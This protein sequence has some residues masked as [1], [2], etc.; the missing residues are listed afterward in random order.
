MARSMLYIGA[1]AIPQEPSASDRHAPVATYGRQ[2]RG[3]YSAC[4]GLWIWAPRARR[5]G[6]RPTQLASCEMCRRNGG[7]M[8]KIYTLKI[9]VP[10]ACH[11]ARYSPDLGEHW[12]VGETFTIAP[13]KRQTYKGKT[14][15]QQIGGEETR[16]LFPTATL[17]TYF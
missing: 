15:M 11:N 13:K 7:F 9:N 1:R 10:S 6:E 14:M 4:R 16:V 17:E 3:T 12:P 8:E 2:G 5:E